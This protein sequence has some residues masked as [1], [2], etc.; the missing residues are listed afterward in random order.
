MIRISGID[1]IICIEKESSA[2]SFSNS[3][4]LLICLV[5]MLAKNASAQTAFAR[6]EKLWNDF[7][8]NYAYF[9]EKNIDW[10]S[11]RSVYAPE[12]QQKIPAKKEALLLGKMILT[13]KDAH[14]SL[15]TSEGVYR[16]IKRTNTQKEEAFAP[17]F[18]TTLFNGSTSQMLMNADSIVLLRIKD[19]DGPIIYQDEHWQYIARSKGLIIDLSDNMGG[20][21]KYAREF[22]E[23][24]VMDT[25]RFKSYRF[26][27]G[28]GRNLFNDWNYGTLVSANRVNYS[29]HI[30]AIINANCSSSCEAFALMLRSIAGCTVIGRTTAGTSGFPR[31]FFLDNGWSYTISTWQEAD[32]DHN[33][34]EDR[35]VS[36]Q[37]EIPMDKKY[38]EALKILKGS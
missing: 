2:L 30:V 16:F 22:L 26:V 13:L 32:A 27:S 21:E 18:T 3:V 24:L 7:D 15:T 28:K 36:P 1:R 14:V 20:N 8:T 5:T 12:F 37:I 17:Y 10:D 25:V 31:Q 9:R 38:A 11:I 6:F 34:I 35:G 29:R 19:L 33:L 23:K 4:L